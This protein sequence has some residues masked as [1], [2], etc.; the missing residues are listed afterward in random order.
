MTK[1]GM[2][3]RCDQG[4]LGNQTHLLWKLLKPDVTLLIDLPVTKGRGR[5]EPTRYDAPWTNVWP[6]HDDVL[7]PAM[8]RDLARAV[9]VVLTVENLYSGDA[10]FDVVR[11]A[12][13][14]SLLVANP[15]LFAGYPADRI[16]VPTTWEINRM[17][18]GT[19]VLPHPVDVPP[20]SLV[21]TRHV[22]QTFLHVAAP[23]MLDRNGTD[24]V[25][26]AL[27]H[28]TEECQLVV[29]AP[30]KP[31]PWGGDTVEQSTS[32][33]GKVHVRWDPRPKRNYWDVY[34]VEADVLVVPRRYG[35]L[36]LPVQEAAACGLP[37]LMT[38][39]DPQRW[40]PCFRVKPKLRMS[41]YPMRGG[42]FNVYDV[43]PAVM[44]AQMSQLVKGTY[45]VERMSVEAS[46]WAGST[47][48]W[49]SLEPSWSGAIEATAS[50]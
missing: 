40:W 20:A 3:V 33:I 41:G 38:D 8:L 13:A 12:G 43:D 29:H 24:V 31:P 26:E 28:V 4:G 27:P 45:D 44:G 46:S 16:V 37:A 35:G 25:M 48:S 11:A 9:D 30:R 19:E 32:T 5:G 7:P 1:V 15:E 50:A 42:K 22:C 23:A 21:R 2:V 10:G 6:W 14:R 39:L 34:D 17:P 36:C 18:Q 49:D 47:L